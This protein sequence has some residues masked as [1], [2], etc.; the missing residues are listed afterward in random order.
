MV[1]GVVRVS[2]VGRGHRSSASDLRLCSIIAHN[3]ALAIENS[4]FHGY[5]QLRMSRLTKLVKVVLV[6]TPARSL[7]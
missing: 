3:A 2:L 7:M 5:V 4:R 1:L 6:E